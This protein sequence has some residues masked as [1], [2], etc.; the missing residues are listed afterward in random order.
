MT[1]AALQR[2]NMVESQ[3]RPSDITDRRITSAMLAVARESFVPKARQAVAYAD[4][5]VPLD[6]TGTRVLLAP[7]ILAKMLQALTIEAHEDVLIIAAGTGYAAAIAGRMAKS[8]TAIEESVA[9]A[10]AATTNLA[11][12]KDI[13]AEVI[14]GKLTTGAPSKAPFDAILIEGAVEYVPSELLQQLGVGGRLIAI[15]RKGHAAKAVL[16]RR[17]A[18]SFDQTDMFDASAPI[19]P[20]FAKA[21]HFTF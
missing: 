12:D 1:D 19:L 3:V 21:A 17:H 6:E 11:G 7:R 13:S 2:K 9:L 4:M 18:S 16:W 20:G 14:T 8:I 5:D 10:A 15:V